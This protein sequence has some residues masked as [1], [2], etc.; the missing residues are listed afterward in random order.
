[1]D[2]GRASD[3]GPSP[4]ADERAS[5][6]VDYVLSFSLGRSCSGAIRGSRGQSLSFIGDAQSA[7]N[8]SPEGSCVDLHYRMLQILLGISP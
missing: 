5:I 3:C 2:C 1:M 7:V 6:D 8:H 4:P